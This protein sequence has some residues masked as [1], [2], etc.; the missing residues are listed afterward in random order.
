MRASARRISSRE[1]SGVAAGAAGRAATAPG[2]GGGAN[3]N[4]CGT[5]TA[6]TAATANTPGS[7][8][9]GGQTFPIAAGTTLVGQN[10]VN[11]G[12]EFCLQGGLNASG[13]INNGQITVDASGRLCGV[14]DAI[15]NTSITIDGRVIT[16][17]P[18]VDI[19]PGVG[20][21][22]SVCVE[23]NSAGQA[24]RVSA[25]IAAT[26]T[27]RV[28]A[29]VPG[30]SITV[31]GQTLPLAPNARLDANIGVGSQVTLSLNGAGQV[32]CGTGTPGPGTG[33][34][35][36]GTGTPGAG[37]GTPG[38]GTGTP[39]AGTPTATATSTPRSS[40]TAQPGTINICGTVYD[41]VT[42][43]P[44]PGAT[45]ELFNAQGG[46]ESVTTTGANGTYCFYNVPPGDYTAVGT[47]PNYNPDSR[48][49][50]APPGQPTTVDLT[51]QP[52]QTGA[53]QPTR[54]PTATP[55][56]GATPTTGTVCAYVTNEGSGAPL[57]GAVVEIFD[58]NGF[59]VGRGLTESDGHVCIPNVPAGPQTVVARVLDCP[60][61]LQCS[62]RLA[63]VTVTAG[64][65]IRVD[66]P[67]A[68]RSFVLY[69]PLIERRVDWNAPPQ[70]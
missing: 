29:F 66:L 40:P 48:T 53:P 49:F 63:R 18:N 21:C 55:G 62:S 37:T 59:L 26:V 11:I 14:V 6:F 34:P 60:G 38:P 19:G 17:A 27:G 65:A 61:A 24:V 4:I 56:P 44:I 33:T 30:V 58:E 1:T 35:G 36:P 41:A 13:Q 28:D 12:D 7:I 54:T 25:D 16:L 52:R 51:L 47:H 39:G 8:T 68:C 23:I 5:V 67:L 45:V 50:T 20:A 10:L 64:Q 42:R 69:L 32:V 70:P 31:N 57:A 43:Q 2:A 22:A 9:I 15:S 46:R 3:V